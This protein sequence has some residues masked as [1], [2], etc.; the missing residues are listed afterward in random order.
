MSTNDLYTADDEDAIPNGAIMKDVE[1]EESEKIGQKRKIISSKPKV[2]KAKKEEAMVI[3]EISQPLQVS[4]NTLTLTPKKEEP[5][6][7]P[8]PKN[9]KK[10][11]YSDEKGYL[12]TKYVTD[13]EE[14]PTPVSTEQHSQGKDPLKRIP[15]EETK[16]ANTQNK[17][18]VVKTQTK[19]EDPA[20]KKPNQMSLTSFFKKK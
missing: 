4:Q 3:E 1:I 6:R 2:K 19:K 10:V 17:P 12:V 5:K 18:S 7:A 15:L 14:V 16:E 13:D 20:E 9:K 8:K 11:T